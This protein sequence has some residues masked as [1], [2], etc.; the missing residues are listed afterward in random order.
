MTSQAKLK[1][2]YQCTQCRGAVSSL[3]FKTFPASLGKGLFL[4][5]V[6]STPQWAPF[7]HT[8]TAIS[9]PP[10]RRISHINQRKRGGVGPPLAKVDP[11]DSRNRSERAIYFFFYLLFQ[12]VPG[13]IITREKLALGLGQM[14]HN[15][16]LMYYDSVCTIYLLIN[17]YIYIYIHIYASC[18]WE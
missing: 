1:S 18:V 2:L 14:D 16:H 9:A 7:I 13:I 10:E 6:V 5:K 3:F 12:W 4:N 8:G 15:S 11:L 17:I